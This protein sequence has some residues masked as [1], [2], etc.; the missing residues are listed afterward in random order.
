MPHY[1]DGT[2]AT[3]GDIVR[4]KGYN[5]KDESG[6]LAEITAVVLHVNANAQACNITV[7]VPD[8]CGGQFNTPAPD[9]RFGALVTGRIEY[10]QCDHF[11]LVAHSAEFV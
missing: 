10:G 3:P 7:L 6:E 9:P 2:P 5:I 4:G 8:G 11:D 1:A